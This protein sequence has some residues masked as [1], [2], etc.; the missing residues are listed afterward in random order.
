M[1][2]LSKRQND[3]IGSLVQNRVNNI[4]SERKAI[5]KMIAET[6][7]FDVD[8][9]EDVIDAVMSDPVVLSEIEAKV[10]E[11]VEFCNTQTAQSLA[12]HDASVD[13]FEEFE[14][15]DTSVESKSFEASLE[16]FLKNYVKSQVEAHV[17]GSDND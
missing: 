12:R 16:A 10:Q 1:N 2:K 15:I 8:P 17:Y 5:S 11:V 13:E 9:V 3:F 7:D 6:G 14:L 4:I